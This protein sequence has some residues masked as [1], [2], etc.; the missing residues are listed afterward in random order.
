MMMYGEIWE[1]FG[2]LSHCERIKSRRMRSWK[3]MDAKEE[4]NRGGGKGNK[5]AG[6]G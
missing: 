5:A 1:G 4:G 6:G 3:D 2:F